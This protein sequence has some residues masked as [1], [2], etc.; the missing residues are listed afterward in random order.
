MTD[1]NRIDPIN[2]SI[3]LRCPHCKKHVVLPGSIVLNAKSNST[4]E[5]DCP[6]CLKPFTIS[7]DESLGV[8]V[9]Q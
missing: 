4:V 7:V 2:E 1:V 8:R 5:P 9:E 3:T 6:R